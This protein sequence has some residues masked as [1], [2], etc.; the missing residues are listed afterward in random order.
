LLRATC[1]RAGF[2]SGS[3]VATSA[4]MAGTRYAGGSPKVRS[5]SPGEMVNDL[6]RTTIFS[7]RMISG[8]RRIANHAGE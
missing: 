8:R 5:G 3:G 2:L 1:A 7:I 4:L 6:K